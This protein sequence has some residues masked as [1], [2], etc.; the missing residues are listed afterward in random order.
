MQTY[1]ARDI[2]IANLR[3][4]VRLSVPH[5]PLSC[6]NGQTYRWNPFTTW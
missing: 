5:T 4:S 1:A 6:H 3:V 2:V